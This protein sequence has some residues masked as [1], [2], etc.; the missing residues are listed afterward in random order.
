[1]IKII[2]SF[3]LVALINV[4]LIYIAVFSTLCSNPKLTMVYT[5]NSYN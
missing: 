1:M 2:K 4:L 3:A 5:D